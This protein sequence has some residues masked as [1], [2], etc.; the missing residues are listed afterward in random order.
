MK[1]FRTDCNT[2]AIIPT[3]LFTLAI[4][5]SLEIIVIFC[6]TL[7]IFKGHKIWL[8]AILL[9][10]ALFLFNTPKLRQTCTIRILRGIVWI[11]NSIKRIKAQFSKNPYN[12]FWIITI[13]SFTIILFFYIYLVDGFIRFSCL[14]L[15]TGNTLALTLLST[16]IP[17]IFAG[18]TYSK[19]RLSKILPV[20]IVDICY[21]RE[22]FFACAV[23][24]IIFSLSF[25]APFL[26][27]KFHLEQTF[28]ITLTGV[29]FVSALIFI[30]VMFEISKLHIS[31]GYFREKETKKLRNL[32]I[33]DIPDCPIKGALWYRIYSS[34]IIGIIPMTLNRIAHPLT[35]QKEC[36]ETA[37]S[38][39]DIFF[40]IVKNFIRDGYLA[41]T[42]ICLSE[43]T[44][45][46]KEYYYCRQ[47]YSDT[48]DEVNLY[49]TNEFKLIIENCANKER[50]K[51]LELFLKP[52][53]TIGLSTCKY[54]KI[55]MSSNSL[56]YGW[57]ELIK[58]SAIITANLENSIFTGSVITVLGDIACKDLADENKA[59]RE[60]ETLKQL[61]LLFA[62]SKWYYHYCMVSN[63]FTAL[64]KILKA[65][66]ETLPTQFHTSNCYFLKSYWF[67]AYHIILTEKLKNFQDSFFYNP[68][69][70]II[71]PVIHP[72]LN[73]HTLP[74]AYEYSLNET[75]NGNT[76]KSILESL[77]SIEERHLQENLFEIRLNLLL[78]HDLYISLAVSPIVQSSSIYGNFVQTIVSLV[79]I[80][81]KAT[82]KM[83]YFK[84]EWVSA[85][86]EKYSKLFKRFIILFEEGTKKNSNH[87]LD[88]EMNT[89]ISIPAISLAYRDKNCAELV[90]NLI[91]DFKEILCNILEISGKNNC[92]HTKDTILGYILLL[93]GWLKIS[94]SFLNIREELES[95]LKVHKRTRT[96]YGFESEYIS[97]GLPSGHLMHDKWHLFP[98]ALWEPN[99]QSKID[100]ELMKKDELIEYAKQFIDVEVKHLF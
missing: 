24:I 25:L 67:E 37:K 22:F 39:L 100:E 3:F 44:E 27:M 94:N 18:V 23:Q 81:L 30:G 92:T 61:G 6:Y 57:C 99:L 35:P 65:Y 75:L 89:L 49:I 17:F 87:L 4:L 55:G 47:N 43:L 53:E 97:Y 73:P 63:C 5:A 31:L 62:K 84:D 85:L 26:Q 15:E 83:E 32:F 7:D 59:I 2:T 42:S 9:F 10:L 58:N 95:I 28:Q 64:N 93:A 77:Q 33:K 1:I 11:I 68:F 45:Y 12:Y 60:I 78:I 41:D 19:S 14:K 13:F 90:E 82:I 69:S 56:I 54:K 71:P 70:E 74:V 20:K 34:Y 86:V 80:D 66:F 40:S 98:S 72:L 8:T 46:A 52:I 96:S 88:S 36:Y 51:F 29:S 21:G 76:F 50:E 48:S 91:R 38:T 16:F 79:Y